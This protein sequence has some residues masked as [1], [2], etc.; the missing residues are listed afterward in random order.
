LTPAGSARTF[1]SITYRCVLLK[2]LK[3]KL[4]IKKY[5]GAESRVYYLG[6]IADRQPQWAL[7]YCYLSQST[8][9]QNEKLIHCP[10]WD[11]NLRP[12]AR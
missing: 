1:C 3:W 4:K 9:N 11:S 6:N 12:L 8:A 2:I 5:L 10:R 7:T